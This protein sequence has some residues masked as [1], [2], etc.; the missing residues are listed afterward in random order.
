MSQL[1]DAV[2]ML[3]EIERIIKNSDIK[4]GDDSKVLEEILLR[5]M[6]IE[7]EIYARYFKKQE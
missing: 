2:K 6:N 5:N 4:E 1:K 3:E 7:A